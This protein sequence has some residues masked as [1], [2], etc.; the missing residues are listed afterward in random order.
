MEEYPK[1]SSIIDI[2]PFLPIEPYEENDVHIP[3]FPENDQP[4]Q[5]A[6]IP[7][8]ISNNSLTEN[9]LQEK[10]YE[11]QGHTTLMLLMKSNVVES[12]YAK[13]TDVQ[14]SHFQKDRRGIILDYISMVKKEDLLKQLCPL[15]QEKFVLG[16]ENLV[17]VYL[18][19]HFS[20]VLKISKFIKSSAC[21]GEY[22]FSQSS[23]SQ[24][25]VPF[26]DLLSNCKGVIICIKKCLNH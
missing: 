25:L 8:A 6:D 23:F 7:L 4:S 1:S 14:S 11:Q 13:I 2:D 21:F 5:L 17:A 24:L 26:C 20:K 3:I 18:E 22:D 19:S 16:F 15:D 10:L 9:S 12:S